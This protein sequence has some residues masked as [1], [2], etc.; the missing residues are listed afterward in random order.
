M[1]VCPPPPI[2]VTPPPPSTPLTLFSLFFSSFILYPLKT[3]GKKGKFPPGAP[4]CWGRGR[5]GPGGLSPGGGFA[6]PLALCH[7][8]GGA[9]GAAVSPL[10]LFIPPHHPPPRRLGGFLR[11][12]TVPAASPGPCAFASPPRAGPGGRTS[13]EGPPQ[14]LT[15]LPT[16]TQWGGLWRP[17]LPVA[18]SR[19]PSPCLRSARTRGAAAAC[20]PWPPQTTR[21]PP[22]AA[23]GVWEGGFSP[24]PSRF[25]GVSPHPHAAAGG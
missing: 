3:T 4:Q 20:G 6:P 10:F 14:P 15:P 23:P 19:R 8:H 11:S 5:F 17:D 12:K 16:G 7:Y 9:P 21:V 18:G 2:P 24:A 22:P 13:A 25:C 1:C